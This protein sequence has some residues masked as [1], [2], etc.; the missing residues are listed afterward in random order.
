MKDKIIIDTDNSM[1]PIAIANTLKNKFTALGIPTSLVNSGNNNLTVDERI[2]LINSQIS[3]SDEPLIISL[4]QEPEE[5]DELEIVYA[6]RNSSTLASL[7]NNELSKE[8]ITVN[9]Y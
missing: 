6:L 2:N 9:K 1:Y 7:L 4:R 3:T 8:G 5:G